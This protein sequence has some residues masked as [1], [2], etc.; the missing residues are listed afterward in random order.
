MKT[1][2]LIRHAKSDWDNPLLRDIERPLNNRGYA[3]ANTMSLRLKTPDLIISSPAVRALSTAL[4]FAR[5]LNY[6]ANNIHI[7][8]TL[9]DTSVKDYL[10]VIKQ[11][12]DSIQTAFLFAHNPII[13][14]TASA[15][16][17]EGLPAEMPTCAIAGISF[18]VDAWSSIKQKSGEL[19]LFDYPKKGKE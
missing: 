17:K 8:Q 14:D 18:S 1:L 11:I 19:F 16:S 6:E 15:L 13:S 5:Q 10:S 9:Y 12:P 3:D 7:K 2:Y 4:I